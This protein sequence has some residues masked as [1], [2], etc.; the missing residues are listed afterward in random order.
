MSLRDYSP[1]LHVVLGSGYSGAFAH[2]KLDK[3]KVVG[4]VPF[5]TLQTLERS[6]VEGHP[7]KYVILKHANGTTLTLQLGRLHGYEGIPPQKVVQTVLEG[8]RAGTKNFIL[9]NASGGTALTHK[10]GSVMIIRDHINLTGQNPL[11][12]PNTSGPRFPDMT[13]SY[14]A[15]LSKQ[16]AGKLKKQ[17][18]K[19]FEGV[20]GGL[21][22]PNYETPAEVSLL[23]KCGVKAVGM[24]TVWETIA[25][26]HAGARTAGVAL[27]T[28]FGAGLKKEKLNHQDVLEQAA[29][30]AK[31]II[32]GIFEFAEGFKK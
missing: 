6:S 13:N 27:I 31:A 14:D 7:G 1:D 19:V 9:T 32:Q 8:V 10:P 17:K 21:A 28:N 5:S 3:W 26:A 15:S 30:S 29:K 12:G 25:L 22:G 20:Y 23:A 4:E 11:T 24:S 16:I 2:L 18:L